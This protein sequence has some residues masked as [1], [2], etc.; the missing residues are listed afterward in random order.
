M[1][2]LSS[3]TKE[4]GFFS[5]SSR[6]NTFEVDVLFLKSALSRVEDENRIPVVFGLEILET[7]SSKGTILYLHLEGTTRASTRQRGR[8]KGLVLLMKIRALP[9]LN[10]LLAS[11]PHL[12]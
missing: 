8:V 9:R 3:G 6:F 4:R 7:R 12:L 10:S 5:S 2:S 1:G 11:L